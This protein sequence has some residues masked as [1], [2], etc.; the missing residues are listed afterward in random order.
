MASASAS[1]EAKALLDT[2]LLT[3]LRAYQEYIALSQEL[4]SAMR[5]GH[6]K[7]AQARRDLSR[8]T[9]TGALSF[10]T[11]CYPREF[12][13]LLRVYREPLH[14]DCAPAVLRLRESNAASKPGSV[15]RKPAAS[16]LR[17]RRQAGAATSCDTAE[18]VDAMSGD[19]DSDQET[20][21]R[22]GEDAEEESAAFRKLLLQELGVEGAAADEIAGALG[23][24]GPQ[25]LMCGDT[26]ALEGTSGGGS[27]CVS[28]RSQIAFAPGG[29]MAGVKQAQ[30]QASLMQPADGVPARKL[31]ER[32]DTR[33]D[34]LR[35]FSVLPP[36]ALRQA[37]KAF[38]RSA[39]ISVQLANAQAAMR[40]ARDA[41]ESVGG[42]EA[43]AA[44]VAS[45][46]PKLT[47]GGADKASAKGA[48][49]VDGMERLGFKSVV[50]E[51]KGGST[52]CELRAMA[53]ATTRDLMTAANSDAVWLR[54]EESALGLRCD[55]AALLSELVDPAMTL[56]IVVSSRLGVDR[57]GDG[58]K[59]ALER[60]PQE[61]PP[62]SLNVRDWIQRMHTL[63]VTPCGAFRDAGRAARLE[64]VQNVAFDL[65]LCLT[66]GEDEDGDAIRDLSGC[67]EGTPRGRCEPSL[68]LTF[69]GTGEATLARATVQQGGLTVQVADRSVRLPEMS[70][71]SLQEK[72]ALM[73]GEQVELM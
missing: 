51:L 36:L 70:L 62:P 63:R 42:N 73:L 33:G 66:A 58:S 69:L 52:E 54:D 34:P 12:E 43:A 45:P 64:G 41:Y 23:G 50:E 67:P 25:G 31:P 29:S 39:E 14:D 72:I 8:T 55:E 37:Q 11:T 65:A 30:F 7:L 49:G 17:K 1:D 56:N 60:K 9:N 26:L 61:P 13:A 32:P 46:D 53:D 3:Y 10:G 47:V 6:I 4:Q 2:H 15:P 38:R 16:N 20:D 28:M 19:D 21:E 59:V 48:V 44:A 18:P 27:S 22:G 35:W 5:E 68:E 24:D 71:E 57:G 40:D